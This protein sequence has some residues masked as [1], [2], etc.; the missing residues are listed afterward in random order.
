MPDILAASL[1]ILEVCVPILVVIAVGVIC[2]WTGVLPPRKEGALHWL[3]KFVYYLG[4]PALLFRGLAPEDF[5]T[6]DFTFALSYLV[7]R[8]AVAILTGIYLVVVRWVK[9]AAITDPI[10]H[11]LGIWI[12]TTWVNL[13]IFGVPI[14]TAF[15]DAEM[16]LQYNVLAALSSFAFQWPLMIFLFE[17]RKVLRE[18][19]DSERE[20]L[21][22]PSTTQQRSALT[23]NELSRRTETIPL[24]EIGSERGTDHESPTGS[25]PGKILRF[26]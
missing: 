25:I 6:I 10:G 24:S 11:F 17:L 1:S 21:I 23:T 14:L 9:P 2:A 3:N 13:L 5:F 19:T 20:T 26:V 22:E 18:K 15:M 4:L 8:V 12:N 7:V 16:A